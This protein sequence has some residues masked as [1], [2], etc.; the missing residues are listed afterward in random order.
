MRVFL[1][2]LVN[3]DAYSFA[4][5]VAEHFVGEDDNN[6][7][8]AEGILA[9]ALSETPDEKLTSFAL[10]I[11]LTG[12]VAIP[13]ESE[14]DFL[15]EGEAVFLQSKKEAKPKRAKTATPIKVAAQKVSGKTKAA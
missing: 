4:D 2:A 6:Q 12:C 8:T 1:R 14:F 15:R 7:Q 5:D 10:R 11:V 13:R 9:A 3:I